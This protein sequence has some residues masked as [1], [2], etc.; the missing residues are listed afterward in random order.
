MHRKSLTVVFVGVLV[1]TP[2]A[3]SAQAAERG[4]IPPGLSQDGSRPAE[5]ALKG[6]TIQPGEASGLPE[7]RAT[8]RC[9]D[10]QGVLRD[11]CLRDLESASGGASASPGTLPGVVIREP[12]STPPPQNPR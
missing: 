11:Q 1:A 10:L 5:G 8:R 4:A 9:E 3:A 12:R 6:G 7:R 2:F